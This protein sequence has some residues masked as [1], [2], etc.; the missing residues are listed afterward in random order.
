MP[1]Q[2]G[3]VRR[4]DPG[5]GDGSADDGPGAVVSRTVWRYHLRIGETISVP[6]GPVLRVEA[7][8][9]AAVDI[10]VEVGL[11]DPGPQA[12]WTLQVFGTGHP[13]DGPEWHHRGSTARTPRGLVWHVFARRVPA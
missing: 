10:W 1:R 13:I 12:V 8:G 7:V 4:G 5:D 2:A 9:D 3:A 11:T 6:D